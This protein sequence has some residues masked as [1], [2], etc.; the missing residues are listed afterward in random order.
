MEIKVDL[1]ELLNPELTEEELN[2]II[3]NFVG[4]GFGNPISEEELKCTVAMQE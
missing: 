2:K 4:M 3:N 1:S